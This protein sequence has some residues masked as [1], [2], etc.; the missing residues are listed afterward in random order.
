MISGR[1]PGSLEMQG[2]QKWHH[3]LEI[4]NNQFKM[5]VDHVLTYRRRSPSLDPRWCERQL[6]PKGQHGQSCFPA[7]LDLPESFLSKS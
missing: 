6:T 1:L 5:A 4:S 3:K 7:A 2:K